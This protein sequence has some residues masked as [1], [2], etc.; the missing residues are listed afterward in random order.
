MSGLVCQPCFVQQC[1]APFECFPDTNEG[2]LT[3]AQCRTFYS[4]ALSEAAMNAQL[5]KTYGSGTGLAG[6]AAAS[7]EIGAAY[8]EDGRFGCY[9]T[10]CVGIDTNA[11]VS[12]FVSV[13]FYNT[14]DDVTGLSFAVVEAAGEGVGFSTS[15]IFPYIGGPLIGTEDQLSV[16][17]SALPVDAGVYQC[18]TILSTVVT[19]GGGP[20]PTPVP[21]ACTGDC[22]GTGQVTIN[23]LI[24]A[25]NIVLD[26][27]PPSACPDGYPSGS[28]LD[29][30]FI[31]QAVHN[32]LNGCPAL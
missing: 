9:L 27:A 19:P 8:G 3:D 21:S 25:V 22:Q 20:T 26:N 7:T 5:T 16:S 24:T 28:E 11:A 13:G 17:A 12:A 29:V 23:D 4:G 18:H 2:P 31:I 32:A 15:Q 14:F 10:D 1:D 6:G 30:T